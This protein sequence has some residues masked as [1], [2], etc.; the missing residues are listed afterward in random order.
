MKRT[1]KML[2]G[3]IRKKQQNPPLGHNKQRFNMIF[4]VD[5]DMTVTYAF[6]FDNSNFFLRVIFP[7]CYL[8][9][10]IVIICSWKT[11]TK[12]LV[13]VWD[14]EAICRSHWLLL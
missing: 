7:S 3:F 2:F 4:L 8:S 9:F 11:L 12:K 10:L 1:L 14:T 6:Y 5:F 13:Y